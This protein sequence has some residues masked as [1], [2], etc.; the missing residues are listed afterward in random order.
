MD[1]VESLSAELPRAL[2]CLLLPLAGGQLL[3]PVNILLEVIVMQ[4]PTPVPDAPAGYLGELSWRK[5]RLPLLAFEAIQ[6]QQ[7][8][9]SGS[10]CRIV[11]LNS[12]RQDKQCF[13]ALIA[14]GAPRLVEVTPEE[15]VDKK[16]KCAPGELMHVTLS[17]EAAVIPDLNKLAADFLKYF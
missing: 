12:G 1:K 15:L 7:I 4:N 2:N 17:G 11:V 13:F 14:Q 8:P 10:D 3:L 16:T 9:Q 6:G 5:Q